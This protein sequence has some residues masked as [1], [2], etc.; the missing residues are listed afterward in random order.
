MSQEKVDRYKAEK[1]K[2]K[3]TMKKEKAVYFMR[4]CVVFVLALAMIGW[5][6][7]SAVHIYNESRPKETAEVDFS[8]I[9]EY[10]QTLMSDSE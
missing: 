3:Q 2:R 1:A 9:D 8:A 5:I 7:Y 6:G 4:R 10:Q